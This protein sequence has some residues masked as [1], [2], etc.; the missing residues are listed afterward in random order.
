MTT[1]FY[2]GRRLSYSG[3]LCT[4]RYCGP[5][6]GTKGDWL[7]VEWDDPTKGK[8]S[9]EHDGVKHFECEV[10]QLPGM[11]KSLDKLARSKQGTYCR[12]VCS[13]NTTL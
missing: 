4:V 7:G 13:S 8:H 9:G 3:S 10:I 1:S 2:A 12:I 6:Q 5:V 11:G